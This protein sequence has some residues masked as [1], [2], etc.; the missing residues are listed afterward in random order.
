MKELP[1]LVQ[2]SIFLL[3]IHR[4]LATF[5]NLMGCLLENLILLVLW[6]HIMPW[7]QLPES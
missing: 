4:L 1:H 5:Y 6:P 2:L 7:L 3:F